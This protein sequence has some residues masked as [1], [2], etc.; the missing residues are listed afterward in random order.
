[1]REEIAQYAA[2]SA[3]VD[4]EIRDLFATLSRPV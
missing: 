4:A 3:E 1:L 2:D